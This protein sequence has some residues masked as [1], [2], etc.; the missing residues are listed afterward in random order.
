M[1]KNNNLIISKFL[2]IASLVSFLLVCGYF[3]QIYLDSKQDENLTK[4]AAVQ[5]HILDRVSNAWVEGDL[6]NLSES[7]Y[8]ACTDLMESKPKVSKDYFKCNPM[9]LNCFLEG[10]AYNSFAPVKKDENYFEFSKILD[11]V[12][13]FKKN[14]TN[15]FKIQLH[16]TCSDVFLPPKKYSA[17]HTGEQN[18]LWDNFGQKNYIDKYYVSNLDVYLWKKHKN[19][20]FVET[21]KNII[22]NFYK[23]NTT[24]SIE[25]K[26]QYCF[27]HGKKVLESRYFDAASFIPNKEDDPELVKKFPFHW[28]KKRQ[29]E[30][31][32]CYHVYARGCESQR[33]YKFYEGLSTSWI[34]MH[35][36]L[37]NYM[38]YLPNKFKADHNLK[39]SS[40]YLRHNS[41]WHKIGVRGTIGKEDKKF[42]EDQQ[43]VAFRCMAAR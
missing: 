42:F 18:Y 31:M 11:P 23:P 8:K 33:Q 5:K 7:K 4:L 25:Q 2:K 36:A 27:E 43:G 41:P 16:D 26:N 21:E 3:A 39:V 30:K 10:F 20:K 14:E 6:D 1:Q 40:F 12:I 32:S 9:F 29:L 15:F 17:G 35:F 34:G 22:K 38:E 13:T 37:G 24:L 28:T 19:I